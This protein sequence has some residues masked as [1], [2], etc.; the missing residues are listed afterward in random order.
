M[1]QGGWTRELTVAVEA[2]RAAG[3]L[4]SRVQAELTADQV[5]TKR[6]QSPVSVGDYAAQIIIQRTLG[7]S[8]GSDAA[9]V[10][11]ETSEA[12]AAEGPDFL[13]GLTEVVRTEWP[14]ADPEA[15]LGAVGAHPLAGARASRA[16][17]WALDPIDGTKGFLRDAHY[18]ISLARVDGGRVTLA[19]LGCPRLDPSGVSAMPSSRGAVLFA[20]GAGPVW[21]A[22]LDGEGRAGR[23]LPAV[24]VEPEGPIR[25]AKSVEKAHADGP[26]YRGILAK[27]RRAVKPVPADGQVKYA[28]L[29]L[30]LADAY[31]RVPRP[32]YRE[33]VWDHAAGA[34][35]AQAAGYTV[36]DLSGGP[37]DF[38][39]PPNL[40]HGGGLLVAP[41][42]LHARLIGRAD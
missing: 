41:P 37:L 11:E 33:K 23:S 29:A 9:V 5:R 30:G 21:V 20:E 36:S 15:V 3:R 10:A 8:L 26:R 4:T 27:A 40:S 34:L 39:A 42:V 17:Y 35:V 19:V 16:T 13:R 12:L 38:G 31:L 25:V 6:D 24:A 28:L 1:A 7:R 32:G 22:P 18:A 2:V 14:E